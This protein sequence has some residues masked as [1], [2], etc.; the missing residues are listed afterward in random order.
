[1]ITPKIIL[2]GAKMPNKFFPC[3]LLLSISKLISLGPLPLVSA[4]EIPSEFDVFE[5]HEEYMGDMYHNHDEDFYG[6]MYRYD[7]YLYS[8]EFGYHTHGSLLVD[9][10]DAFNEYMEMD[11]LEAAVIAFFPQY[12]SVVDLENDEEYLEYRRVALDYSHL[13]RFAHCNS[14]AVIIDALKLNP[15]ETT[16]IVSPAKKL[17][18]VHLSA[19]LR[20]TY[21]GG[22]IKQEPL[23]K[24]IFYESA[25]LIDQYDWRS[26]ERS[27]VLNIPTLTVFASMYELHHSYHNEDIDQKEMMQINKLQQEGNGKAAREEAEEGGEGALEHDLEPLPWTFD[28]LSSALFNPALEFQHD[29]HFLVANKHDHQLDMSHYNL[30]SQTRPRTHTPLYSIVYIYICKYCR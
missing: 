29:L 3:V 15:T 4:D 18:K 23:K 24:F 26:I 5:N 19:G 12:Q 7:E 11:D 13:A 6:D 25:P 28:E 22:K 1:L 27:N 21:P 17:N 30:Q 14:K 9:D 16:V 2:L 20:L 10:I 8:S